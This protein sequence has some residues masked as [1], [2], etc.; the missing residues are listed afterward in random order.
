MRRQYKSQHAGAKR[1]EDFHLAA[2]GWRGNQFRVT[3]QPP[4]DTQLV[5]SIRVEG[6]F[7][8]LYD[9][10]FSTAFPAPDAAIIQSGFGTIGQQKGTVGINT[11]R[12]DGEIFGVTLN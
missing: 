7:D 8:D 6:F 11:V 12:I 1:N 5:R 4:R 9:F 3:D 10:D 2:D